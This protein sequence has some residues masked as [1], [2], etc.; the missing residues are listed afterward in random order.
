M[1]PN[2]STSAQLTNAELL[3]PTSDIRNGL[4][5]QA[6]KDFCALRSKMHLLQ[7]I[8]WS[9][10]ALLAPTTLKTWVEQAEPSSALIPI[11]QSGDEILPKELL[12]VS[13]LRMYCKPS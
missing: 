10:G 2:Q 12:K 3:A 4:Y 5:Q 13:F 6:R 7:R 1:A 8:P 9:T 11:I